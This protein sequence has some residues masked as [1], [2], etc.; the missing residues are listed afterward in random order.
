MSV[1]GSLAHFT[2]IHATPIETAA[3]EESALHGCTSDAC[4]GHHPAVMC[5]RLLDEAFSHS[6]R[7]MLL[8]GRPK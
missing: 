3:H 2:P 7:W 6:D 8:L 5:D 1:C 4:W